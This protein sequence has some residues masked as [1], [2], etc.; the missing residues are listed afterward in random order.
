LY[1]CRRFQKENGT[2]RKKTTE[3]EIKKEIGKWLL[4]I[5]KYI[6]TA[7]LI[8]TFLGGLNETR[9]FYFF[10]AVI[11]TICFSAGILMLKINK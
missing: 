5:A 4:D 2:Q 10:G 6:T 1:F 11:V 9:T 7:V 3:K 8:T